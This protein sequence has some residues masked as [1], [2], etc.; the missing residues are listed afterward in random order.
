MDKMSRHIIYSL[1]KYIQYIQLTPR[2]WTMI[3]WCREGTYMHVQYKW[4]TEPIQFSV[5]H[6]G[7]PPMSVRLSVKANTV[8]QDTVWRMWRQAKNK[9]LTHPGNR[10][11]T[12]VT[13]HTT[14]RQSKI[15][16][17]RE[18]KN[19]NLIEVPVPVPDEDYG[20]KLVLCRAEVDL[21]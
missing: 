14:I 1:E 6:E 12:H 13:K 2:M 20:I 5:E 19:E 18:N 17:P 16:Q 10:D 4:N 15:N 3:C 8:R 7:C 11:Q 9:Q 21:K